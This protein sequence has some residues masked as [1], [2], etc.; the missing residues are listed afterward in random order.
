MKIMEDNVKKLFEY[1]REIY[2][3]KTKVV[4]DYKKFDATIEPEEFKKIYSNIAD[5]H[6]FSSDISAKDEYFAIK[7]I[8]VKS[9]EPKVPK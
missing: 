4:L 1:L 8:N 3:L 6:E 7:Y 2:K 5:I 9:K